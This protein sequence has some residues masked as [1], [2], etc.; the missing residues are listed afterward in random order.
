M[1]CS[2]RAARR[3]RWLPS[4]RASRWLRAIRCARRTG[5]ALVVATGRT[6]VA[7][8][9]RARC[10]GGRE[11]VETLGV[12]RVGVR[13]G[14]EQRV[15]STRDAEGI[16]SPARLGSVDDLGQL[17]ETAPHN[18]SIHTTAN[19]IWRGQAVR[20]AH[21]H[22]GQPG[23]T[24]AANQRAEWLHIDLDCRDSRAALLK[25]SARRT[26]PHEFFDLVDWVLC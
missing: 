7:R 19:Q 20:Q 24:P 23:H 25:S 9:K 2:S 3:M 5:A 15:G 12:E 1:A 26:L 4:L 6:A 17:E 11:P 22:P 21:L 10:S 13:P 8:A 14:R 16:V 18:S